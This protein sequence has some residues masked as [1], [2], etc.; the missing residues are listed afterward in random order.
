MKITNVETVTV[1]LPLRRTHA[2]ALRVKIRKYVI[3]KI[4]TNKNITGLG[5][6]PVL[7][8]WG[9]SHMMYYGESSG[10]VTHM[11]RDYLGQA[12]LGQNPFDIE[13]IH[14]I[15]DK[16]VKGYPY[17]KASLDMAL[18]DIMGK[19]LNMPV[20]DL[21]GG[22][23]RRKV[24]IAHSIGI[25]DTQDALDEAL[26]AA[27]EGI[28]TIKL[29][30]GIDPVRDIEIVARMREALGPHIAITV[31]ANQGWPTAKLAIKLIKEMER[32]S[33]LFAEQPVEGFK[34][35]AQVAHAVD[36][37]IMHDE[38]AWTPQDVLRIIE[39]EAGDIISL[40]TTKPGGVSKAK[41]VAAV[42]EAGGLPCNVNGSLE[43][44]VGN[45]ANLHLAASTKI[46]N[47]ACVIPVTSIEGNRK[48]EIANAF[49]MDDIIKVPFDYEDGCLV[50]PEKQGMGIELD[51]DKI[52]KYSVNP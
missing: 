28:R 34:Q 41:K 3:V 37:P 15:M 14:E 44:G 40:Y 26:K 46:V 16:T 47:H 27:E 21:L 36:T 7:K 6:A 9:G 38:G 20:Y 25:M 51:E 52:S 1:T 33:I 39:E 8:E 48:S 12:I 42:A 19:A 32:Y 45:A 43:T 11:I 23:Y 17:A 22:C 4:K 24:P 30:V 2:S 31:D 5:E 49:Y 35:M 18:Y 10:T 29:K 50:V 13:K